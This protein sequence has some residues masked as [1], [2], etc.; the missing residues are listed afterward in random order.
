PSRVQASAAAGG[1]ELG[2]GF[3][4]M[5]EAWVW[6]ASTREGFVEDARA[7]RR[8]VVAHIPR[9]EVERNR[10]LG[11]GGLRDVEFT[12]QLLQMVHGRADEGLQG[13]STLDSLA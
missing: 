10:K 6:Q 9:A 1:R 2:D 12:V 8:R 13:R 5:V 7:M 3:E 11:P 4:S